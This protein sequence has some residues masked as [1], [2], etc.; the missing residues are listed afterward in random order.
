MNGLWARLRPTTLRAKIQLLVMPA[1]IVGIG[2]VAFLAIR[3]DETLPIL[4]VGLVGF[5]IV[6]SATYLSIDILLKPLSA[7]V[8]VGKG[9]AGGELS[10]RAASSDSELGRLGRYM[11]VM[12]D[13]HKVALGQVETANQQLHG[14]L[15]SLPLEIALFDAQRRFLYRKSNHLYGSTDE[16]MAVGMTVPEFF[17]DAGLDVTQAGEIDDAIAECAQTNE[18]VRVEHVVATAD[19][20]IRTMSRVFT[21]VSS[22]G[23]A[24]VKV[25]GYGVD[26]TE[27]RQAEVAL[28]EQQAQLR[29]AQKMESVGRLAGGVAH[30]FNN[31]LT[32]ILGFTDMTLLDPTLSEDGREDLEEVKRSAIRAKEL[33]GQL[34]AYSRKQVV[35]PE[36]LD[37][38]AQVRRTEKMLTRLIGEHIEFIATCTSEPTTVEIDPGQLEQ[39]LTNL[40]V[41]AR[42]AMPRG[43]V[44]AVET[45]IVELTESP[46]PAERFRPG[47]HVLLAIRDTGTG[48]DE[49]TRSMIFEPFFTTKEVEHGTGLGLSTVYGIVTQ[50]G[51]VITVDSELGMG[52]TFNVYLPFVSEEAAPPSETEVVA[53]LEQ[54]QGT[55]LLVEDQDSVRHFVRRTLERCGYRVLEATDGSAAVEVAR[56]HKGN[57][58]LLLSDVMMPGMTGPEAAALIV[59][60]RPGLPVIFMSAYPFDALGQQMVVDET[61]VYLEKPFEASDLAAVVKSTIS[62]EGS[63]A[64]APS[65]VDR[66]RQGIGS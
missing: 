54:G 31:L 38:S 51:G 34:L 18:P 20:D 36:V 66:S 4:V 59:A 60:L 17:L 63:P 3:L 2:G 15:E 58:D 35:K 37:V 40:I 25:I 56:E 46:G 39:I 23:T 21:P 26:V 1:L 19:G 6:L 48:M 61:V 44:V 11:N 32:S 50:N 62:G 33:T 45:R 43:G 5:A 49:D 64:P 22:T 13:R 10:Q 27:Q 30:D 16:R 57:L 29:Q 14:I 28:Q 55:V 41:N 12:V 24:A 8:Q 65:A 42:D 47:V 9:F 7:L 53:E 52:T